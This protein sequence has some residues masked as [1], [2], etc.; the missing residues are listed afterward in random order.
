MTPRAAVADQRFILDHVVGFA[1]VA[2]TPRFAEATPDT[3]AAV[4]AEAARLCDDVIAPLNR[5]GDRHPARLE[6]GRVRTSP[7]FDRGYRAIAEAAG[8]AFRPTRRRG[9]WACP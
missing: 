4:L 3:V 5:D 6:N 1:E 7:G 2:A 8:S 9:A